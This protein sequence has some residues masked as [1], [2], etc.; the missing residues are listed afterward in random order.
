MRKTTTVAAIVAIGIS[1]TL[2]AAPASADRAPTA[3]ERA[4]VERVLRAGGYVSWEEIELD[5]DGPRWEVDDARAQDGRRFDIKIDPKSMRIIR[6]Q[7][8]RD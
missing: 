3:D 8:D 2:F 1:T 7:L 4:A 5:D 6:A